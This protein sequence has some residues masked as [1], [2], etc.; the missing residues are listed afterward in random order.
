MAPGPGPTGRINAANARVVPPDQQ[1]LDKAA[2]QLENIVDRVVTPLTARLSAS[3]YLE[4]RT[5][6][7]L[8][9]PTVK[10][11]DR[12]GRISTAAGTEVTTLLA[13]ARA[14]LATTVDLTQASALGLDPARVKDLL[15]QLLVERLKGVV[16]GKMTE[17]LQDLVKRR[18]AFRTDCDTE[19]KKVASDKAAAIS[20]D[21]EKND[22]QEL[23]TLLRTRKTGLSSFDRNALI[24]AS[25][26][27]KANSA[28]AAAMS[29]LDMRVPSAQASALGLDVTAERKTNQD[30]L[31]KYLERS[32]AN[33]L[34]EGYRQLCTESQK[35]GEDRAT[36][37]GWAKWISPFA[38]AAATYATIAVIGGTSAV[39][40]VPVGTV[41][42]I[43]SIGFCLWRQS[44]NQNGHLK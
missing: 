8:D 10:E 26:E 18:S 11:A 16:E 40:W 37:W 23:R 17:S 20:S 43:A 39:F 36:A 2:E 19:A 27:A 5:I 24:T 25:A 38:V 6:S 44:A 31:Q 9:D 13:S 21:L 1:Y 34:T 3:G 42:G 30:N 22:K 15:D 14:G 29:E 35:Q 4:I 33:K 7:G 32:I 41:V 28:L 12:K